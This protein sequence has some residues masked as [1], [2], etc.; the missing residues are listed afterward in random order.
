MSRRAPRSP[1]V[2]LFGC[3]AAHAALALASPDP[4]LAPD[5]T[6]VGL[7]LAVASRPARWPMLCASAAGCVLVWAVRIPAAVA[8]GYL[9]AGWNVHWV[10]GQWDASDERVQGALVLGSA[11]LLTVGSLWLQELWSLPVAGRAAAHLALTYGAFMVV[12]RLAG[13]TRRPVG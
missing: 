8:A 1:L 7:V 5:L 10:A 2:L 13:S 9:A 12:R 3:C 4:W 6:L 11:L